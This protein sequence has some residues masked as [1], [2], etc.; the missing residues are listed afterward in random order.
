MKQP[1][2]GAPPRPLSVFISYAHEDENLCE[3]F[4]KHLKQLQ[5]DGLIQGWHDR[6]L[7]AGT[8]WAGKIDDR[9]NAADIIILLVS[10]DFLASQYCYDVEMKRALE[11]H[12]SGEARVVP[13]ILRPS[14]WQNSP[15]A[16]LSALPKD[17]KPVVDW[18]TPDHGF[19]NVA[20]GLR[21]VAEE[22]RG[23]YEV[24][25]PDRAEITPI[26]RR[27]PRL[28]ISNWIAIAVTAVMVA[29]AGFFGWTYQQ[30]REQERRYV[31]QGDAFLD[32]GRYDDARHPYQQAVALN[33]GNP[34]A[35]LGLKIVE[36]AGL[37]SNPVVF[38]Q[39]L[40]RILKETPKDSHLMVLQGDCLLGQNRPEEA[41]GRY[42][43]AAKL[44][45]Q[46][47]EAYFRMGVL[48]DQQ[49]EARLALR[50]YQRAVELSPSSPH[51][52][53]NLAD[54]YFKRGEYQQ[55]IVE[56]GRIDRFPLAALESA[57]VY[58]LL[59]QLDEAREQEL[60]STGWLANDSVMA[61]PENHWPWYFEIGQTQ[62]MR[63]RDR[64]EK[65]CYAWLEL[66]ATM[67]L[68]D[69]EAATEDYSKRAAQS[70]G[71]RS[72]DVKDVSRWELERVAKE[73]PELAQR[74]QSYL[75]QFLAQ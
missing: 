56:Y 1:M 66:S 16:R 14:D 70:C 15:F 42:R 8:E 59:G 52:R 17:G 13:V 58:R 21:R 45:P 7:T 51:Y 35:K 23:G 20:G 27:P 11:R 34:Q 6:K 12:E 26:K 44:N 22:L 61:L 41:M 5:R 64:N 30:R 47:A 32:V 3:E 55:A 63:L 50:M 24:A 25:A 73:R 43:D 74:V 36:L 29:G 75:Q 72:R 10:P 54:Q 49:G 48:Y 4:L 31:A 28:R 18:K 60:L 65:L 33:P 62:G 19:L 53:D 2:E 9:L 69:D 57:K 46:L 39:R 71:A 38:Q 40:Y 67:Y 37:E 68:K